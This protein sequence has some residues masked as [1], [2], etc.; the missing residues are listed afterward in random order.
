M[1]NKASSIV[2]DYGK[3]KSSYEQYTTKLHEL[4]DYLIEESDIQIHSVSSRTKDTDNLYE[5]IKRKGDK[6][7]KLSDITDLSGIR[8][9]CYLSDQVDKVA[10]IIEKNFIILNELSIDKRKTLDP[11]KFGYLSLHFVVKLSEDRSKL[12]EYKR[13]KDFYCEIQIRSILQHAWAEIEHDLGYKSTI[14]IP[15][16]VQRRFYRLAGLLELAD[17]EFNRIKSEVEQYSAEIDANILKKPEEILIDKVS[18][19]HFII[20]SQIVK[21]LDEIIASNANSRLH[22]NVYDLSGYIRQIAYFNI[23]TID[24]L[25]KTIENNKE[26]IISFTKGWLDPTKSDF[27]SSYFNRGISLFYLFYV[28]I[29]ATLDYEKIIEYVKLFIG[30]SEY[31]ETATRIL[32]LYE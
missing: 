28:L 30:Y 17:D 27:D 24:D 3:A 10:D 20:N 25:E 15:R 19:K 18:L 12:L 4:V 22:E 7:N 29:G 32:E 5:K 11:D 26:K 9:I 21:H 14:E 2:I 16:D 1:E 6:Y 31:D 13:F 8:I 23:K